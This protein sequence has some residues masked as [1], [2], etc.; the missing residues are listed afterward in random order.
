MCEHH[1]NDNTIKVMNNLAHTSF[2]QPP[3]NSKVATHVILD[4]G[5]TAH[6]INQHAPCC[7]KTKSDIPKIVGLPNGD[8]LIGKET[9]ELNLHLPAE[10]RKATIFPKMTNMSLLSVGTLCDA[11]MIATFD[12]DKVITCLSFWER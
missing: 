7:N 4:T 1:F 10:A 8:S 9:A 6:Y 3:H 5:A 11:N 2:S 12:K